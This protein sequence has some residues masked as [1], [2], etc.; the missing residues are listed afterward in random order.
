MGR[1]PPAEKSLAQRLMAQARQHQGA[2]TPDNG[3]QVAA[4]P[5]CPAPAQHC[6]LGLRTWLDAGASLRRVTSQL[7]R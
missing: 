4:P 1:C 5:A 3:Q 6:G 2:Q 7:P